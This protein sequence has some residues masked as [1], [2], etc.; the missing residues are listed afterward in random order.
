MMM[1]ICPDLVS[2]TETFWS[3]LS[4]GLRSSSVKTSSESVFLTT[5]IS[6]SSTC[7]AAVSGSPRSMVEVV[8]ALTKRVERF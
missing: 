1:P 2:T 3:S 7:G 6:T 5:R 4:S 8:I